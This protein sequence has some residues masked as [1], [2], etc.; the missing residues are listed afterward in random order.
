MFPII[1]ST[2]YIIL[3]VFLLCF[4]IILYVFKN[5]SFSD[6]GEIGIMLLDHVIIQFQFLQ[7]SFLNIYFMTPK[8]NIWKHWY[9]SDINLNILNSLD[10]F[11]CYSNGNVNRFVKEFVYLF[12]S[13]LFFYLFMKYF[14]RYSRFI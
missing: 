3:K 11:F 14:F 10:I 6:F 5:I 1:L 12:L 7:L 13:P 8:K 4:V 9:N 2:F